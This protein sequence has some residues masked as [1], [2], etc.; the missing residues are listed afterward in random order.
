MEATKIEKVE[1]FK[2]PGSVIMLNGD[3]DKEA[4]QSANRAEQLEEGFRCSM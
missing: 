2:Y 1:K 4:T 3:L